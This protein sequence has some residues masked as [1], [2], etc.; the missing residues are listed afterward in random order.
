MN[1]SGFL[2]TTRLPERPGTPCLRTLLQ[3]GLALLV[4]SGCRPAVDPPRFAEVEPEVV[5]LLDAGNRAAAEAL[6]EAAIDRHRLA[7]EHESPDSKKLKERLQALRAAPADSPEPKP[8]ASPGKPSRDAPKPAATDPPPP[9][10]APF[11]PEAYPFLNRETSSPFLQKIDPVRFGIIAASVVA[12]VC[13]VGLV[14]LLVQPSRPPAPVPG[15]DPA[16][17]RPPA[18]GLRAES[19]VKQRPGPSAPARTPERNPDSDEIVVDRPAPTRAATPREPGPEVV[20]PHPVANPA[21]MLRWT[22]ETGEP[23]AVT[24]DR[25]ELARSGNRL[26][27]GRSPTMAQL[28]IALPRVSRRHA[29]V[30]LEGDQLFIQDLDSGNG[31]FVN[32]QP[33]GGARRRVLVRPGDRISLGKHV[34]VQLTT[35]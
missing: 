28:V 27:I 1:A 33:L 17:V 30:S 18:P 13:L 9:P 4:L 10:P 23:H 15:P 22:D 12:V 35:R 2:S 3:A 26:V 20:P 19:F 16:S 34:D 6:L 7:S 21:W 5:R 11:H 31:T 29:E 14:L 25:L 24:F 32:G 8:A